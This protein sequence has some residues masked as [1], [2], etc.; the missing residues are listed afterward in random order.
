MHLGGK[1]VVNVLVWVGKWPGCIAF[2]KGKGQGIQPWSW[3]KIS[4]LPIWRPSRLDYK[5]SGLY[6][7]WNTNT[8]NYYL[9]VQ[10]LSHMMQDT[11]KISNRNFCKFPYLLLTNWRSLMQQSH[12]EINPP[13]LPMNIFSAANSKLISDASLN[14]VIS[15][16]DQIQQCTSPRLMEY[17]NTTTVCVLLH[18]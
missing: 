4:P 13:S 17:K 2:P 8:N 6:S 14:F 10:T 18:L 11:T 16:T 12:L 3:S 1:L 15:K 5:K 7:P 9:K